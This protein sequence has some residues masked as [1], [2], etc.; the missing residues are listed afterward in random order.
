MITVYLFFTFQQFYSQPSLNPA[1]KLIFLS[2]NNINLNLRANTKKMNQETFQ[3]CFKICFEVM[4]IVLSRATPKAIFVQS[5]LKILF[6]SFWLSLFLQYCFPIKN[7]S[8]RRLILWVISFYLSDIKV[9]F[10]QEI[11]FPNFSISLLYQC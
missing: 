7:Y 10:V 11:G 3:N 1:S 9:K 2:Q 4:G 6:L 5:I 8:K